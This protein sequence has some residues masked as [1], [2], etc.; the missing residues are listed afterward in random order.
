MLKS[1]FYYIFAVLL[2]IVFFIQHNILKKLAIPLSES[3]LI[4]SYL[5]NGILVF[6]FLFLVKI[7]H[8]KIKNNIGFLFFGFSLL[9]FVLFFIY[10]NPTYKQDSVTTVTE[11]TSFFVPYFICIAIEILFLAKLL[12][13]LKF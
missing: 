5:I 12:N 9:K 13:K 2:L 7:F 6:S 10:I 4:E 3:K 8:Q 11:F 1:K